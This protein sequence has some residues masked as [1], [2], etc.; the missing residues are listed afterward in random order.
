[1]VLSEKRVT[2]GH[3]FRHTVAA[4]VLEHDLPIDLYGQGWLKGKALAKKLQQQRQAEA[5]GTQEPRL[6]AG[7]PSDTDL[8]QPRRVQYSPLP[9]APQAK[10]AALRDYMFSIVIENAQ[11]GRYF[12]EKL[13]DAIALGTVPV[14]W[15]GPFAS[16][17]LLFDDGPAHTEKRWYVQGE[18]GPVF[19]SGFSCPNANTTSNADAGN[20]QTARCRIHENFLATA[21]DPAAP[22]AVAGL[23]QYLAQRYTPPILRFQD[24][25]ELAGLISNGLIDP[26]VFNILQPSFAH[27]Q[28]LLRPYS[29]PEDTL[30][31]SVFRCLYEYYFNHPDDCVGD[32]T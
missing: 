1:M 2:E 18:N 24:L 9:K 8:D 30:F 28:R 32:E 3:R 29:V 23:S 12:T 15:G 19:F 26:K 31:E 4:W 14:Y 6:D 22:A 16:D 27:A 7:S 5:Q 11:V 20:P 25:E 21:V 17:S 13:I 10:A